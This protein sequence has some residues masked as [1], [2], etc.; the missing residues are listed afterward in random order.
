MTPLIDLPI[1]TE[2]SGA[3]R[4]ADGGHNF[5][6]IQV[7]IDG[8][9]T[10]IVDREV[11]LVSV[12]DRGPVLKRCID[13]GNSVM[14]HPVFMGQDRLKPLMLFGYE[15]PCFSIEFSDSFD[16]RVLTVHGR[17]VGF[18]PFRDDASISSGTTEAGR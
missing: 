5:P 6:N 18:A 10:E 13:R 1:I 16:K 11:Y 14:L 3:M 17:L 12:Q 7:V 4:L 2:L 8:A 15:I 9:Q